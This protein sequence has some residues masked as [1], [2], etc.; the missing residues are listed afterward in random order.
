MSTLELCDQVGL[1][2]GGLTSCQGADQQWLVSL[3]QV[4]E[5]GINHR[6]YTSLLTCLLERDDFNF[7]HK[8][9]L[10]VVLAHSYNMQSPVNRVECIRV[11]EKSIFNIDQL[12][13]DPRLL[14]V[15]DHSRRM[16]NIHS[17]L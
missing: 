12:D 11:H 9:Q 14:L 3:I 13:L 15:D 8:K 10:R 6:P 7:T 2:F 4:K 1:P 16:I 5:T 17:F